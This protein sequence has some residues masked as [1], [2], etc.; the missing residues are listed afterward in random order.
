MKKRVTSQTH[1]GAS[2][3]R[4]RK[5]A[6]SNLRKAIAPARA[7]NLAGLYSSAVIRSLEQSP[8]DLLERLSAIPL[9]VSPQVPL[10]SASACVAEDSWAA[11][12]RVGLRDIVDGHIRRVIF[13]AG[14]YRFELVAE[15]RCHQWEFVGRVYYRGRVL[16]DMVLML[17]RQRLIPGLG[18]FFHWSSKQ[19]VRRLSL[20]NAERHLTLESLVW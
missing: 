5:L 14:S 1:G 4:R 6:K 15:R 8:V 12:A 18:G 2:P 20:M 10:V 19:A 7:G 3:K 16:N 11:G 17:G 13:A 9:L